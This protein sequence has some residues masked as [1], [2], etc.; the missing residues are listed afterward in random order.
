[1]GNNMIKFY[2]GSSGSLPQIG[3]DGALYVTVDEPGLYHGTGTGMK[4]LGGVASAPLT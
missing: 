2:R 4:R 3:E 1:M